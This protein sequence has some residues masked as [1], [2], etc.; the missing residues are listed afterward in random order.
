MFSA[1]ENMAL[2]QHKR[3]II[4]YVE[5]TMPEDLLDLGVTVLVMQVSCRA[6]GCVPLETVITII[7]PPST[8]ELLPGLPESQNSG[9]FTTK[10][11]LPMSDI[12]KEDVLEALPPA[13][14]G[15]RQSMERLC[16]RARDVMLA[17]ITQ[18]CTSLESKRFMAQYLEECLGEFTKNDFEA[19]E[20]GEPFPTKDNMID[21]TETDVE[22][23]SDKTENIAIGRSSD[24]DKDDI[25]KEDPKPELKQ[26]GE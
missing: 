20:Y 12:T 25:T 5:E 8:Q 17:Q 26:D 18:L 4:Q 2:R 22:Q 11:L 21:I 3:R 15:G 14:E 13:F 19:P 1:N 24:K 7:F 10:V 16:L 9:K 6:P 23:L